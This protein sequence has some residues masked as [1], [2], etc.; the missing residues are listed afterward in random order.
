MRKHRLLKDQQIS[1]GNK[2]A[3]QA[4][5]KLKLPSF[6]PKSYKILTRLMTLKMKQTTKHFY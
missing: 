3:I 4:N 6:D 5:I 1:N 2:I